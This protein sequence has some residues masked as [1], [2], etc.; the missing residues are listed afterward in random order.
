[1][2]SCKEQ[3]TL[4]EI[5]ARCPTSCEDHFCPLTSSLA[6]PPSVT[7]LPSRMRRGRVWRSG[8][9]ISL[10]RQQ[11]SVI[12]S[13]TKLRV[14]IKVFSVCM[15]V[16]ACMLSVTSSSL[17]SHGLAPAGSVCGILQARTLEWVA[18]A[19]FRGSSWPR[20]WSGEVLHRWD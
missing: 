3:P 19:F 10:A 13:D 16:C 4:E 5:I 17:Q 11:P 20:D 8:L 18:T 12:Q 1:M 6:P 2:V 9:C 7:S 14:T 15:C